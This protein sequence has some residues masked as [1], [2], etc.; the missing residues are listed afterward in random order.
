[1]PGKAKK[2]MFQ[3][4]VCNVMLSYET[5][6]VVAN[7]NQLISKNSLWIASSRSFEF[8][9]IPCVNLWKGEAYRVQ[10]NC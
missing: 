3:R 10:I 6:Q 8:K 1:M 7:L 4:K 2:L 5:S 9:F